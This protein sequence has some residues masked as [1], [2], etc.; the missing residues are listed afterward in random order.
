LSSKEKGK[1]KKAQDE[2][3]IRAASAGFLQKKMDNRNY[4]KKTQLNK[5]DKLER[6]KKERERER[7]R[8][9]KKI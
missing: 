3:K 4:K 5:S 9:K 8:E 7:E 1:K 6:R 2:K